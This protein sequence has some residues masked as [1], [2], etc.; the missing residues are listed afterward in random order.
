MI[1]VTRG[2]GPLCDSA[3]QDTVPSQDGNYQRPRAGSHIQTHFSYFLHGILLPF[4][5]DSSDLYPAI[6]QNHSSLPS[7]G[8]RQ[9]AQGGNT[10]QCGYEAPA[11]QPFH[12]KH[13]QKS[14]DHTDCIQYGNTLLIDSQHDP[15]F[16]TVRY[17]VY[18]D[19]RNHLHASLDQ[20]PQEPLTLCRHL[21]YSKQFPLCAVKDTA[22]Y[23]P[24]HSRH[25]LK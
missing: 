8:R 16:C 4:F 6:L 3:N 10:A 20:P 13:Q 11:L 14:K 7:A 12:G 15:P 2:F 24:L 19:G 22:G 25:S 1:S 17:P 18:T 5:H 9:K 23:S 21:V